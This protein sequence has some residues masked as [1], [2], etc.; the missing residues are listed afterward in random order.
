LLDDDEEEEDDDTGAP[1][2]LLLLLDA[3]PGFCRDEPGRERSGRSQRER[4]GRRRTT[5]QGKGKY[6][7]MYIHHRLPTMC[8]ND[9]DEGNPLDTPPPAT[10]S[11]RRAL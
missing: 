1:A 6:T 9:R 5:V 7:C 3:V 2:P 4:R 10:A 8:G 11:S